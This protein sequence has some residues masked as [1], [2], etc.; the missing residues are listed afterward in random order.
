MEAS[1]HIPITAQQID[2]STSYSTKSK[3]NYGFSH[4]CV[5]VPQ[6]LEEITPPGKLVH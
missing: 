2:S 1:I 4:F 3:E 6:D 5:E